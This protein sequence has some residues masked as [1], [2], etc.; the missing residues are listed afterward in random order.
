MP[1]KLITLEDTKAAMLRVMRAHNEL[2]VAKR[3]VARLFRKAKSQGGFVSRQVVS[4]CEIESPV[5][6]AGD[7]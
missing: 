7:R 5:V 3:E 4:G 6:R 1:D 2:V